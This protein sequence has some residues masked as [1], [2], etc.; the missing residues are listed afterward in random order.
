MKPAEFLQGIVDGVTRFLQNYLRFILLSL[1]W[2]LREAGRQQFR[3]QLAA[4]KDISALS[5]LFTSI[6]LVSLLHISLLTLDQFRLRDALRGVLAQA[7][8]E[9]LLPTVIGALFMTIVF[10]FTIYL[11][12]RAGF[13][14]ARRSRRLYAVTVLVAAAAV[15]WSHVA[16]MVASMLGWLILFFSPLM[17]W[18]SRSIVIADLVLR[19]FSFSLGTASAFCVI[20]AMVLPLARYRTQSRHSRLRRGP[21]WL[22]QASYPAMIAI[23]LLSLRTA[24]IFVT[25]QLSGHVEVARIDCQIRF[26]NKPISGIIVLHNA[27]SLDQ[28]VYLDHWSLSV[29]T[30]IFRN[31]QGAQDESRPGQSGILI[32]GRSEQDPIILKEGESRLL[33]YQTE[34]PYVRNITRKPMPGDDGLECPLVMG[35]AYPL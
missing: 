28:L 11:F 31:F 24:R 7:R 18:A 4:E 15:F 8:A 25:N 13:A 1:R 27:S 21:A 14:G 5:Y 29:E 34:L 3:S 17:G 26:E 30:A 2:P 19:Y 16:F 9:A 12:H 35:A 20:Y 22:H 6:F 23:L 10:D 33:H 32:E